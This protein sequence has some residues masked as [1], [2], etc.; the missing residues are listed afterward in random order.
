MKDSHFTDRPALVIFLDAFGFPN[1]GGGA[2]RA[3]LL[4]KA[5]DAAG[6]EV[7]V[8]VSKALDSITSPKNSQQSGVSRSVKYRYLPGRTTRPTSFVGRRA[9]DVLGWT[10]AM[11]TAFLAMSPSRRP[12]VL[13][14]YSDSPFLC[15]PLYL[16]SR[17]FRQVVVAEL[18][19]WRPDLPDT[20]WLHKWFNK[21]GLKFRCADR[22]F[23]IS[24]ALEAKVTHDMGAISP[25][26][27]LR[28]PIMAD[29]EE[30]RSLT[31]AARSRP[32]VLWSGAISGYADSV[33][34]LI[35]V[36]ARC[37]AAG[38]DFD[39]LLL[40]SADASVQ[41]RMLQECDACNFPRDHLI[42]G[43]YRTGSELYGYYAGATALL[44]PLGD[45]YRSRARFPTKIGEYLLCARPVITNQVGDVGEFLTDGKNALVAAP[46]DDAAFA[47]RMAFALDNPAEAARIG[48]NGRQ[49]AIR[50]FH[51]E[52][53][54]VRM[55]EFLSNV[56]LLQSIKD[57]RSEIC[58][59]S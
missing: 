52:A 7:T 8:V 31:L 6:F 19:E 55:R 36:A 48:E 22:V 59:C 17:I 9:S 51:Y 41:H 35:R 46:D 47:Q 12:K 15:I 26:C 53:I 37:F 13:Y 56:V 21:T 45:D 49:T 4:A 25:S 30:F 10:K 1:G 43:G 34:F 29:P 58:K 54:A 33:M 57:K 11:A 3:R 39:F 20:P 27:V 44:A 50:E 24:R 32:Y 16:I 28:V 14:L 38:H 5:L 42:F 23:A 40:G 18:C 2:T